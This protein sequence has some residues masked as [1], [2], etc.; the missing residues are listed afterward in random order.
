MTDARAAALPPARTTEFHRKKKEHYDDEGNSYMEPQV[1]PRVGPKL[2]F[3]D[4][5]FDKQ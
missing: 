4:H 3:P 1:D 2:A 5:P